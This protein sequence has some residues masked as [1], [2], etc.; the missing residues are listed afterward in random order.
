MCILTCQLSTNIAAGDI[1]H[2]TVWSNMMDLP[3]GP[4]TDY[5]CCY[6]WPQNTPSN[7]LVMYDRL[8][9]AGL[10]LVYLPTLFQWYFVWPKVKGIVFWHY[11]QGCI[12]LL[13][14]STHDMS[15]PLLH[16]SSV[17]L[18]QVFCLRPFE[19]VGRS[20]TGT[21]RKKRRK[22]EKSQQT[23]CSYDLKM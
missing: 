5:T 1:P 10:L 12:F 19:L 23:L 6:I 2:H 13:D 18:F 4:S 16:I 14:Y 8:L 22:R 7:K 9:E 15:I 11:L 21:K 17:S 20:R 3:R